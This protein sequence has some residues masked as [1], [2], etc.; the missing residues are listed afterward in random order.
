MPM[1]VNG[2]KIADQILATTKVKVRAL[3]NRRIIPHLAIVLLGN[4]QS[5]LTYIK[6]KREA[7]EKIG[8]KF[9]LYHLPTKL[10]TAQVVARM[11]KIQARKLSGIIV[12]LPL[13]RKY[14]SKKILNAIKP[15]LDIDLMT[16]SAHKFYGPKGIGFLYKKDTIQIENLIHGGMQESG[17]RPGTENVAGII[18]LAEALEQSSK[19]LDTY[20]SHLSNLSK[21]LYEVLRKKIPSIRLNGPQLGETRLPG[22]LSL[23]FNDIKSFDLAFA[24]DQEHIYVSTGSACNATDIKPSHVLCA[25][26]QTDIKQTGTIRVSFGIQ[27]KLEDIEYI[28][29]KIEEIYLSH[30]S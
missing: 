29:E 27:N 21:K 22:I 12:Q 19:N 17:H 15:E 16:V 24:L 18:G 13:P 5:S 23:S 6:K 20:K 14:D 10:A 7:A 11:H 4:D 1:I 25:I 28:A 2:R 3:N 8:V 9:S 26:K 30:R